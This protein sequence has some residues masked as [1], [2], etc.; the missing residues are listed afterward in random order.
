MLYRSSIDDML[1]TAEI[2]VYGKNCSFIGRGK[3]CKFLT[4]RLG[5]GGEAGFTHA[6][7]MPF[8]LENT[9]HR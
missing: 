3:N 8:L 1:M 7:Y 4:W 5:H 2:T 9:Q 6:T